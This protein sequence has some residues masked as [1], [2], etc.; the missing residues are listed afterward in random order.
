MERRAHYRARSDEVRGV[1]ARVR[2]SKGAVIA[3]EPMNVSVDGAALRFAVPGPDRPRGPVFE[4]G[5]QVELQFTLP[6]IHAP[7]LIIAT[8][9]HRTEEDGARQYGF[10]FAGRTQLESQLAPALYRLFNRRTS[11]RVKPALDSPIGVT[12]TVVASGSTVN[13]QLLDIST[14]GMGFRAP[15][16][17]ES[18]LAAAD[19]VR[20][21]L[22]LPTHEPH[23]DLVVKIRNRWL[24][25]PE[26][27]YGVEYDLEQT[28]DAQRQLHVITA[29]VMDRRRAVLR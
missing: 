15:L 11:Y 9:I 17:A 22:S 12:L 21:S 16:A 13:A 7:I 6:A 23:L 5:E 8:V 19:R 20:V 25:G 29:F 27:R 4:V 26:V 18:V 2:T 10:Q 24:I 14:G 3:G 1:Q 28:Q